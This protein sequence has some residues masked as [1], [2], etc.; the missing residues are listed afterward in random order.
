MM[1]IIDPDVP[2]KEICGAVVDNIEASVVTEPGD[3]PLNNP[4]DPVRQE[5]TLACATG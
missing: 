2:G 4:P 1:D 5:A 3:Q